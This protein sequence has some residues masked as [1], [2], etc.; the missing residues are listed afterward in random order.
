MENLFQIV[1]PSSPVHRV[2]PGA[3]ECIVPPPIFTT[4]AGRALVIY[5]RLIESGFDTA[6]VMNGA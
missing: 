2:D 1:T 3:G 5:Q 6:Q 4:N